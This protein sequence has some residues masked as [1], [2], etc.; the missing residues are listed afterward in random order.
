MYP[1]TQG[2]YGLYLSGAPLISPQTDKGNIWHGS[3][4]T[5][6]AWLPS[7]PTYNQALANANK[8]I[9]GSMVDNNYTFTG[10]TI[11]W[12]TTAGSTF[13]PVAQAC[14]NSEEYRD[15]II[16][17][18]D[19]LI[20]SDSM[21]VGEYEEQSTWVANM[22]LFQKLQNDT[23][24]I[25]IN[26]LIR[27]FYEA[28]LNGNV[29]RFTAIQDSISNDGKW[30]SL[31]ETNRLLNSG[32][33]TTYLDS[34]TYFD[35]LMSADPS[36]PLYSDW[37]ASVISFN[38]SIS[39]L[40]NYNDSLSQIIKD[41]RTEK[42][43]KMIEVNDSIN[44]DGIYEL[45]EQTINDI[46]LTTVASD[47]Y[48]FT[49]DQVDSIY[50]I[51]W[52]CPFVGG[53]AVFRARSLYVYMDDTT[54]FDDDLICISQGYEY[55]STKNTNPERIFSLFPNPAKNTVTLTYQLNK[56]SNGMV[57]VSNNMGETVMELAINAEKNEIA[58]DISSLIN[59]IYVV[60][61]VTKNGLVY[62]EKLAIVK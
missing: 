5:K 57:Q 49:N 54:F 9:V 48:D 61:I 46:Y 53:P 28:R 23:S 20:A 47:N 14:S 26:P 30:E 12:F 55:R 10:S 42:L 52:Q 29:G 34:V 50:S 3:F 4:L 16:S 38:N 6:G 45:N 36:N 44:P 21:L 24:L 7:N 51:A 35:S 22:H 31:Y 13:T 56:N 8:F 59:N 58:F 17:H 11:D 19:S 15:S 33:I 18:L 25:G 62:R 43:N 41:M 60:S 40:A 1:G 37:E 2:A 39:E 32:L 27:T